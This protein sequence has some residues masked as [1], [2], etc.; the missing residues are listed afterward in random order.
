[1]DFQLTCT[2]D[3]SIHM[4][5]LRSVTDT[6]TVNFISAAAAS[7][8]LATDTYV[9]PGMMPPYDQ[10]YLID[11]TS[12]LLSIKPEFFALSMTCPTICTLYEGH[13]DDPTILP[14]AADETF[15][16]F[17]QFTGELIVATDNV[18]YMGVRLPLTIE[19]VSNRMWGPGFGYFSVPFEITYTIPN[20]CIAQIDPSSS[21]IE[22]Q[23]I[24]WGESLTVA[25]FDEYTYTSDN[26]PGYTI[27]Y[28]AQQVT[29]N[30]AMIPLPTEVQFFPNTRTFVAKKCVA[31]DPDSAIDIECTDESVLP[32]TKQFRIVIIATLQTDL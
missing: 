10:T 27:T 18:N 12:N 1:M 23:V 4:D 30:G 25:A 7:C 28:E 11:G 19:C 26:C 16:S 31:S 6:F 22:D 17:N 3:E 20:G 21:Y 8:Q 24:T 9:M 14:Q 13:A 5:A 32:Y 2:S 15:Q 29:D